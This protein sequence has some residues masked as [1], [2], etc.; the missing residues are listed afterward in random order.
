VLCDA[1]GN[2]VI[3]PFYRL[4]GVIV[5]L[6]IAHD[7]AREVARR[8][9]DSPCNEVSLDFRKPQFDLVEPR[10]VGSC[11]VQLHFGVRFEKRG[12]RLRLVSRE[13]VGA[14][15]YVV[16]NVSKKAVR[17]AIEPPLSP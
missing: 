9:E 12:D 16:F 5:M 10:R 14:Q 1:T 11:E 4:R 17:S 15:R 8:G 3:L 7:F 6:D 2:I 13:V